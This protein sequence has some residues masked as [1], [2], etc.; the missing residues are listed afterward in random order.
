MSARWVRWAGLL[1]VA[2][3]AATFVIGPA[4]LERSMNRVT[5]AGAWP[6]SA[7]AA[8]LHARLTIVDL[9]EDTLLWR[10]DLRERAARGHVDLPRAREGGLALSVFSSVTQVP[11]GLNYERNSGTSDIL[12][13]IAILQ[14]QP[15][16]TWFS[17]LARSLW[18]AERLR[19]AAR[20]DASLRIVRTVR[21]LD[22]GLAARRGGSLAMLSIEGLHDLEGR[23]A[24]LDR[25]WRAGFRMGGLVHFFD[26]DLAGSMAGARKRGLTPFGRR[27]V[28]DMEARGM[29]VDLAHASHATVADVLRVARKPVVM[30]HGGVKGTCDTNR[31]L[32]DEEVRGIARTGGVVG[33]GLWEVATCARSPAGAARAMRYVRDLVGIQAVAFGS[34]FDGGVAEPMDV[35]GLAALTQALLDEG[36]TEDEVGA[37]MGG[38][39]LRVLRADLPRG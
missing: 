1:V 2:A 30:S 10:R 33:I 31:N 29:V 16:R 12:V 22:E 36:F 13:P 32:T 27:I 21:D 18:H 24:N 23:E 34:D 8:A 14:M 39:A 3:L 7:R 9:H 17:P 25:L 11:R 6:V 20:A 5:H 28:A 4:A 26:N 37:A 15:V 35:S 19:R 38:N